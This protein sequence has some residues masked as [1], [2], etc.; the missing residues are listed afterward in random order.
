MNKI[1]LIFPLNG[2]G[3]RFSHFSS[4]KPLIK[5]FEK[6]M[7]FWLLDNLELKLVNK[8]IIPY[9]RILKDYNFE[10]KLIDRYGVDKFCFIC[11]PYDT[12]G[13]AETL[14]FALDNIEE[15]QLKYNFMCM[16]CDTF[17]FDNV[18]EKYINSNNKNVIYYFKDK[19]KKDIFSF[20]KIKN[21][22]VIE[23]AEKNRISNFAN[24]GIFCFENGYIIKNYCNIL[25]NNN[26]MQKNEFYISG[27]YDLLIKSKINVNAI[28]INNFYCA[29]TPEQ[30]QEVVCKKDIILKYQF[31]NTTK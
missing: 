11:V 27:I 2:I 21:N 31:K 20:I 18:I 14:K 17:Y 29:G 13:A 5:I 16:D 10:Q 24:C 12:R 15:E 6:E 25:I 3:N 7:F 1:N 4:P 30:L 9:N 8:I 19:T 28:K 26:I 23:I 22:S